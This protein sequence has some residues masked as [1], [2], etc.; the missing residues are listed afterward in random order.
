MS[1]NELKH[2]LTESLTAE[3]IMQY[4]TIGDVKKRVSEIMG[5]AI[6]THELL[7]PDYLFEEY[8]RGDMGSSFNRATKALSEE[9]PTIVIYPQGNEGDK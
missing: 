2:L 6:W 9:I 8:L 7:Y 4:P 3:E 1:F 5:R